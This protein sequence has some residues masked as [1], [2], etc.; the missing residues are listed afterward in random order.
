M[1]GVF[2]MEDVGFLRREPRAS[3][4]GDGPG[5]CLRDCLYREP[6]WWDKEMLA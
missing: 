1:P 2:E 5:R 4:E 6:A 3:L